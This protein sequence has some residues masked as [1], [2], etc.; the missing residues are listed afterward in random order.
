M[1]LRHALSGRRL[2]TNDFTR[3]RVAVMQKLHENPEMEG[4][5]PPAHCSEL[6][7]FEVWFSFDGLG[8]SG[9]ALLIRSK[10]G[11]GTERMVFEN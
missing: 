7:P 5:A 9:S 8:V 11:S 10:N 1:R 6:A 4:L 3:L 2:E